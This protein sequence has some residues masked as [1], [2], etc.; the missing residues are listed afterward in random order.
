MKQISS[1]IL[2]LVHF[3]ALSW[4]TEGLKYSTNN[5]VISNS[6]DEFDEY[7]SYTFFTVFLIF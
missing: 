2:V 7:V 3:L 4:M 5:E 1:V 6:I